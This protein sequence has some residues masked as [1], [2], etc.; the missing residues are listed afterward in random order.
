[1]TSRFQRSPLAVEV[2]SR[3]SHPRASHSPPPPAARVAQGVWPRQ[4]G[5]QSHVTSR[6]MK[7]HSCLDDDA[8]LHL[9]STFFLTND[10]NIQTEPS[11]NICL[12]YAVSSLAGLTFRLCRRGIS[13]KVRTLSNIAPPLM[14]QAPMYDPWDASMTY[15]A[16]GAPINMVGPCTV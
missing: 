8:N 11:F 3:R 1:M 10:R 16:T 15:P 13:A 12:V 4:R 7:V 5:R 14:T 6:A 2:W 9:V